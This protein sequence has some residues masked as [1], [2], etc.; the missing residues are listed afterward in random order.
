MHSRLGLVILIFVPVCCSPIACSLQPTIPLPADLEP[1]RILATGLLTPISH[2]L[3]D[4]GHLVPGDKA[5]ITIRSRNSPA[6]FVLDSS[7]NIMDGAQTLET[8]I[9]VADAQDDYFLLLEAPG[10]PSQWGSISLTVRAGQPMPE[11]FPQVFVLNFDGADSV[12]LSDGQVFTQLSPMDLTAFGSTDDE[13]AFLAEIEP[14]IRG[15]ICDRLNAVF[16]SYGMTVFESAD[17][18]GPGVF[19]TV[20]FT[21]D[22]GPPSDDL[23][24]TT[25]ARPATGPDGFAEPLWILYGA[26]GADLGNHVPDDDAIVFVGSFIG[27][28]LL[29]MS[30]NDMVNIFAHSA[31][32]EMGHLLGLYHVFRRSDIMWGRPNVAFSRDIDFGRAQVVFGNNLV[33]FLFQDPDRYLRRISGL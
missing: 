5:T 28:R 21:G 32:H 16:V 2:W 13:R 12:E 33:E 24:D 8:L 18:A 27:Q 9:F 6:V 26:A 14:A 31:A 25:E 22:L 3:L 17:E 1:Q 4:I 20:Y 15:L 10:Q 30:I 19:S 11:R 7:G 23:F 29:E